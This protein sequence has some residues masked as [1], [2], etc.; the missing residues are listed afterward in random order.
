[1]SNSATLWAVAYQA[2]LSMGYFKKEYWSGLLCPLTGDLPDPGF[3]LPS[4]SLLHWQECSLP[5]EPPGKSKK[6]ILCSC[7]ETN[8][9]VMCSVNSKPK[10]NIVLFSLF[11]NKFYW[12]KNFK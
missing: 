12:V 9:S 2:P 11:I 4:F 8:H 1:M 5:L 3:K 6:K 10:I 7:L